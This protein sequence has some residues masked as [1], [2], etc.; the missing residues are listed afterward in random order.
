MIQAEKAHKQR[1]CGIEH[2]LGATD[3]VMAKNESADDVDSVEA[4][5]NQK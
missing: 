3:E 2:V 4:L 1:D 5:K